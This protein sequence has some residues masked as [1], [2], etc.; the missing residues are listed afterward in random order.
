MG[1]GLSLHLERPSWDLSWEGV[2]GREGSLSGRM[3]RLGRESGLGTE[4]RSVGA[5]RPGRVLGSV[6]MKE[7][8]EEQE[9]MGRKEAPLSL[10]RS[11]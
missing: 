8:Q 9:V 10:S 1:R 7:R 4:S 6:R 3:I 2:P 5:A 11:G